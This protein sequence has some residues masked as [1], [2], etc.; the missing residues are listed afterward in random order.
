MSTKYSQIGIKLLESH[1][2]LLQYI[3]FMMPFF[4]EIKGLLKIGFH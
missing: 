2:L 3:G 4:L 1:G